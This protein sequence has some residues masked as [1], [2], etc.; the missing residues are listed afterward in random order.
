MNMT[1]SFQRMNVI[2]LFVLAESCHLRAYALWN[3]D[4]TKYILKSL[5]SKHNYGRTTNNN[6]MR[7]SLRAKRYMEFFGE[8]DFKVKGLKA[9][10]QRE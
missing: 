1:S 5:R 10:L 7:S 6:Q 8:S 2:E 9:M 3:Q 4:K